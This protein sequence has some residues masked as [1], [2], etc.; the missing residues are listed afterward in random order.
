MRTYAFLFPLVLGFLLGGA[1]AFTAASSRRWGERR[2]QMATMILRNALGIP[3]WIFGFVLAW[4]APAPFPFIPGG[5]VPAPG[6][7]LLAVRAGAGIWGA[8]PSGPGPPLA[9]GG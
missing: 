1:S 5:A 9:A 8:L 6:G 4:R 2:G 7:L 3:L